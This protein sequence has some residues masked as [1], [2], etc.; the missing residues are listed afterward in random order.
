MFG[1]AG[2]T[3]WKGLAGLGSRMGPAMMGAAVAYPVLSA[4][5]SLGQS[6]GEAAGGIGA[7][8]ATSRLIDRMP[9]PGLLRSAT[10]MAVP[11]A[12]SLAGGMAGGALGSSLPLYRRCVVP[13]AIPLEGK[14]AGLKTLKGRCTM[15]KLA[16]LA[17][18]AEVRGV[19]AAYVDSGLLKVASAQEFD[20]LSAAVAQTLNNDGYS[21]EDIAAATDRLLSGG[22]EKAAADIEDTARKA[23]LGELLLQQMDGSIDGPTF[24]KEAAILANAGN[25]PAPAQTRLPT[26]KS[27]LLG[28][29]PTKALLGAGLGA[30]ALAGGLLG[31][32]LLEKHRARQTSQTEGAQS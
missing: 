10:K 31:K 5:K 24:A 28:K 9:G 25:L 27:G 20:T 4:E 19:L 8:N 18:E 30:G 11:L 16:E 21:V 3:L 2:K 15:D 29:I 7:W 13:G 32:K 17:K 1:A 6:A 22:Q 23:A 26:V 14:T 12:A